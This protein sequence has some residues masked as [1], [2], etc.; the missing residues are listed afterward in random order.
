[1]DDGIFINGRRVIR[2]PSAHPNPVHWDKIRQ[3]ALAR[4]GNACRCCPATAQD[5]YRL[6]VHHRHYDNWG[7]E[8]L[9]DVV[10]VC[11]ACHDAIT[12]RMRELRPLPD[13]ELHAGVQPVVGM[14]ELPVAA[15]MP[16][17]GRSGT[18]AMPRPG[19]V[20]TNP[21]SAKMPTIGDPIGAATQRGKGSI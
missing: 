12:D 3:E 8:K 16:S 20:E 11:V 18:D 7:H 5:G 19:A 2:P 13:I 17:M 6:E 21:Q 1:M 9:E 14:A 4:D 15:P 10:C